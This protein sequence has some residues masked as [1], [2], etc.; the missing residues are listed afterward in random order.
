ML[1]SEIEAEDMDPSVPSD[2]IDLYVQLES[3]GFTQEEMRG[4]F[5]GNEAGN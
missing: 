5:N 2:L 4:A 3:E 1:D